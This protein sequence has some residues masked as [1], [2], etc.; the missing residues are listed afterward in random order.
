MDEVLN[1]QIFLGVYHADVQILSFRPVLVTDATNVYSLNVDSSLENGYDD[2][3]DRCQETAF[4][5]PPMWK[6]N[7]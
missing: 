7:I 2:D 1:K 4:F 3:D 6:I 5:S